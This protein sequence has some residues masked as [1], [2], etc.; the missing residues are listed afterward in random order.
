LEEVSI[1]NDISTEVIAMAFNFEGVTT[2]LETT[3]STKQTAITSAQN[4]N[5]NDPVN[6]LKYQKEISEWTVLMNV[7]S[8]TVKALKDALQGVVQKM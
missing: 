1:N 5:L 4:A 7:A 8:T 2:A 6:M 3:I